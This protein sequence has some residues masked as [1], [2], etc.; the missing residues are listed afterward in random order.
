LLFELLRRNVFTRRTHIDDDDDDDDS[1]SRFV[2]RAHVYRFITKRIDFRRRFF[3]KFAVEYL[4][5]LAPS[6]QKNSRGIGAMSP[7]F[8]KNVI[9]QIMVRYQLF[10]ER[11]HYFTRSFCTFQRSFKTVENNQVSIIIIRLMHIFKS[12]F[13]LKYF[14][15]GFLFLF[16]VGW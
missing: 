14:R 2:T 4:N 15:I 11:E 13:D 10:I 5:K 1:L 3:V 12:M 6:R 7:N 9:I 8:K 16:H